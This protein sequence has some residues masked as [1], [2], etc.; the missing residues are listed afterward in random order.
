MERE[1]QV[2]VLGQGDIEHILASDAFDA[3]PDRAQTLAFLGEP[4]HLIL[5]AFDADRLIGFASGVI[6]LHPDKAPVLFISEVGVNDTYQRNGIGTRLCATLMEKARRRGCG[7]VWLATEVDNLPARALYCALGA[8]ETEGI[9]VCDW[10][11]V[12]DPPDDG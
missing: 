6:L 3:A 5:G 9:V 11:G 8:R 1:M 4:N 7:G 10:G 12:M 2:R